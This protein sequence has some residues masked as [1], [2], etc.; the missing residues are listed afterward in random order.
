MMIAKLPQSIKTMT[1]LSILRPTQSRRLWLSAYFVVA[2][3]VSTFMLTWAV[4]NSPSEA[5]TLG[6][7]IGLF[8]LMAMAGWLAAHNYQSRPAELRQARREL[9]WRVVEQTQNLTEAL[10]QAQIE[11]VKHQAVLDS[12]ADGVIVFDSAGAIILANPAAAQLLEISTP[13]IGA[14]LDELLQ[15]VAAATE[16]EQ[17]RHLFDK[18]TPSGSLMIQWNANRVLSLSTSPMY[19]ESDFHSIGTVLIC[20]D[21]T[22][23]SELDRLKNIFVSMISHELRTPLVG[24]LSQTKMLDLALFGALT[25]KQEQSIQRIAINAQRLLR[26]VNDLLDQSRIEAGATLL[27]QPTV[28]S[29]TDLVEELQVATSDLALAKHL[30]LTIQVGAELPARLV[31]DPQRLLQILI[32]LVTNAIKYTDI[33]SIRVDLMRTTPTHWQLQVSDTG[34]GIPVEEQATVFEP[35]RRVPETGAQPGVGLGLTIVK[36]LVGLMQGEIHLTSQVGQG[37]I[38]TVILPLMKVPLATEIQ[39]KSMCFTNSEELYLNRI[40]LI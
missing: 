27:L 28:F 21:V 25:D 33:G 1:S 24:I 36:H 35:F 29:V 23:E 5:I 9:N 3:L 16:R 39:D 22:H 37:S 38:F 4:F 30:S 18:Q 12:I 20:R 13:L 15:C 40:N 32:N 14:R 31:G 6:V 26:L 8:I 34:R 10:I 11:S 2:T 17:V 7:D 19:L